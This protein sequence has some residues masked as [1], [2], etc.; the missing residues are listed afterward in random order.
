M[1][2]PATTAAPETARLE[3]VLTGKSASEFVPLAPKSL[4]DT[5]LRDIEVE[6]LVLKFLHHR[7]SASGR[8]ISEQIALPFAPLSEFLRKLK[9]AQWVVYKSS[10]QLHDYEYEL[11]AAGVERASRFSEQCTYFGAA[12]VSL[13]D[14]CASVAAQSLSHQRPNAAHLRQALQ[15]LVLSDET[16]LQVGQAVRSARALFLH[17]APGNGKTSIAER[18]CRSYGQ[19]LWI[20]R[21]IHID[22]EII[23]LFDPTVHQT[24]SSLPAGVD[25]QRLDRRWVRIQRPTIVVGGELTMDSLELRPIISSGILEAPLHLKSNCGTLVVDDFGRQRMSV[26]ELLNRWIV[27]LERRHDYLNTPRGKKVQVPFDQFIVFAT[28][29]APRDLV[30]EAFWRRI[31]YK[32]NVVDPSEEQF[33]RLLK[34]E[35]T[36]AGVKWCEQAIN[37][38]IATHYRAADR[39]F[40][41]CHPRDLLQQVHNL[42]S[43]LE[44]EPVLTREYLDAAVQNYFPPL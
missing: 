18:V 30:D 10:A 1:Q 28:N 26:V 6:A 36:H 39:P 2:K 40:R 22:G 23:R 13:A 9:S 29:L 11:T 32:V 31:P 34:S 37:E 7:G 20:P 42:C 35:A 19:F 14:Y 3:Q 44:V 4:A 25:P 21:A 33:R 12:P 5:G 43:F 17:G 16:L 27:P 38:L 8:E 41:A 24:E 15:D